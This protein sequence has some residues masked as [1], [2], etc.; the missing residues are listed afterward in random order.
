MTKRN[1]EALTPREREVLGFIRLG[2]TNEDIAERLGITLDGAKYHVS[3]VLSKLGVATREEAADAAAAAKPP[4]RAR[5]WRRWWA[6]WPLAAK[7]A[8][9]VVV[10]A[11]VAGMGVLAWGVVETG[12]PEER[13]GSDVTDAGSVGDYEIGEPRH[14]TD[15][16]GAGFWVVKLDESTYIALSDMDTHLRFSTPDCSI[17][18]RSD[19][20]LDNQ[21]GWFRG[22]CSGSNFDLDGRHASGPSP[23]SMYRHRLTV[24]ESRVRVDT[25]SSCPPPDNLG[26][27]ACGPTPPALGS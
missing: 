10:V 12:S 5:E 21:T 25:S 6:A 4:V 14:F 18:W 9:A 19:V 16:E 23:A 1:V 15:T 2:L 8:G 13:D 17:E 27:N 7:A 26:T 11:A 20:Q 24:V 22:K 3:Q